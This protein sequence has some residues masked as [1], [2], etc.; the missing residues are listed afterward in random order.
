MG[1]MSREVGL[2][3]ASPRAPSTEEVPTL[4]PKVY[5]HE[6]LW[7]NWSPRVLSM[8]DLLGFCF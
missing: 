7:A 8:R 2:C 6:I 3:D 1:I 4:E 5:K